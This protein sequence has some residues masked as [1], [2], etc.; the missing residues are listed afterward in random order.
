[1]AIK[2]KLLRIELSD[3]D[4]GQTLDGLEVRAKQWEDTASYM[5]TGESPDEFF[6][7]EECRDAEEAENIASHYRSIIAKIRKEQ[8]EQA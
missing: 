8:E 6:M 7:P 1:V 5:R 3:N 4:L 2:E